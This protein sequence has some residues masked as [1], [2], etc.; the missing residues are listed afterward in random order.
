MIAALAASASSFAFCSAANCARRA[1]LS[2][3]SRRRAASLSARS[4][5]HCASAARSAARDRNTASICCRNSASAAAA[6]SIA[7]RLL[8]S[9]WSMRARRRSTSPVM[10]T[11]TARVAVSTS[12]VSSDGTTVCCQMFS[13]L[14]ANDTLQIHL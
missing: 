2:S 4:A 5:W 6:A 7:A 1:A 8:A 3:A 9:C 13:F 11:A 14:S 10:T 12:F